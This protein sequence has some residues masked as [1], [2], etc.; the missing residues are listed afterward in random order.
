MFAW[1]LVSASEIVAKC[2]RMIVSL[3]R[4]FWVKLISKFDII[5]ITKLKDY[6]YAKTGDRI[7]VLGV[8]L[9]GFVISD[10]GCR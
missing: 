8:D 6:V 9:D 5:K 10:F 7:V 2:W 3:E 4:Q 1:Y